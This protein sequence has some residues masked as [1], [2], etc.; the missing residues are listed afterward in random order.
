MPM[1]GLRD[2]EYQEMKDTIARLTAEVAEA[3]KENERLTGC[4]KRANDN[5]EHFEREWYLTKDRAEQAE[6]AI[7]AA[8]ERADLATGALRDLMQ[9]LEAKRQLDAGYKGMG[10]NIV[11][12]TAMK[13][14][15]YV[16]QAEK[17]IKHAR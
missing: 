1:F 6:A 5:H 12:E 14:P 15:M 13:L 2:G 4:L 11:Q 9:S 8:N 16:R 3:K 7:A 10:Y 17:V